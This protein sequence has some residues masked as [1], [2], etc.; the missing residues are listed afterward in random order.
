[1]IS[2][3][4]KPGREES[5]RRRHPWI[6][7]GAIEGLDGEPAGGETVAVR[8]SG[9]ELAALGAFSPRSQIAV[10][11]WSFDPSEKIEAGFLRRRL[12][13]AIKARRPEQENWG[14]ACGRLAFSE[15]DGLPGLVIDR[16]ADFVVCQF[17]AAG[18]EAWRE[19]IVTLLSE[20]THAAGIYERS[21]VEVRA[22][23][24]LEPRAGV[25]AGAEPPELVEVAEGEL[26]FLVDL[27]RGQKTGFYLDQRDNR[28]IA[29]PYIGAGEVLDCFSNTGSF[30]AAALKAGA[31]RVTCV[32]SSAGALELARR[33]VELNAIDPTRAVLEEGNVF[34][35]LRRMRGEERRF[36]AVVLDPPRFADSRARLEAAMRGYKDINLQ[37]LKVLRSGGILVTFS[38]SHH[39]SSELLR[40]TLAYAAADAGREVQILRC[41]HQA[42]DHPVALNFPESEYLKGF[43]CR[44][45]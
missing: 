14:E 16:Y 43:L 20:I 35:V 26:R 37:A 24:G 27:R 21:D 15:A 41:L 30:A 12:E 2:A 5:L 1:M 19:T 39:M 33:N 31:E 23:E 7:S 4:L 8:T 11:I 25:L 3:V 36:D 10:R 22:K 34:G 44:V 9:G 13:R 18:A 6:F 40:M 38:C 45:W 42:A 32:D 29:A 17:L 28:A